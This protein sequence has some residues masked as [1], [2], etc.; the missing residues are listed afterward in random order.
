MENFVE[1]SSRGGTSV[2]KLF[3]LGMKFLKNSRMLTVTLFLSIF[4]ACFLSIS[5]S[6]L[7]FCAENSY[8]NSVHVEN[9]DNVYVENDER[10]EKLLFIFQTL[11]RVLFVIVIC[12]SALLIVSVFKEYMRKYLHDM[13][14]IRTIGGKNTQIVCIFAA[15][16]FVVSL[17]G[18]MAGVLVSVLFNDFFLTYL[19]NRIHI[20]S[21]SVVM[22]WRTLLVV[23]AVVFVFFNVFVIMY[24]SIRQRVLPIQLLIRRPLGARRNRKNFLF[25]RR[26]VGV[27][28]YLGMKLLIPKCGQ[29][30][31]IIMIITLI[32]ALSYIGQGTMQL[33][34]ENQHYIWRDEMQDGDARAEWQFDSWEDSMLSRTEQ[35]SKQLN[36]GTLECQMLLGRFEQYLRSMDGGEITGFFVTDI[37]SFMK[38]FRG[39]RMGCWEDIPVDQRLIMTEDTAKDTGYKLGD[40]IT[41]DTDW[42]NGSKEFTVV[43][44]VTLDQLQSSYMRSSVIIETG[45]ISCLD[46]SGKEWVA[47]TEAVFYIKGGEKKLDSLLKLISQKNSGFTYEIYEQIAAEAEMIQTQRIVM[48]KLILFFLML[49]AGL[50]WVNSARG[51][52]IAGKQ[53]YQVLRLLGSPKKQVRKIIWI[54]VIGYMLA[55]ILLGLGL[56]SVCVYL[57]CCSVVDENMAIPLYWRNIVWIAFYLCSL[58]LMLITTIKKL[59]DLQ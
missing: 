28:N 21:V 25:L 48:I 19:N 39:R 3:C 29:N 44:I 50:G 37:C 40:T 4:L 6:Q 58:S 41:L 42:L 52:L 5:M 12:I 11:L 20:F 49:I 57:L 14:I 38:R 54:Q 18:C 9:D 15:M 16:S 32:T 51:M 53:D 1:T 55:G 24:F 31:L 47:P 35:V 56:G 33:L 10:E 7:S 36:E 59:A 45:N 22:D 13:A 17:C 26:F 43:E 2:I 27:E 23:T 34:L 46:V 8:K 30:F